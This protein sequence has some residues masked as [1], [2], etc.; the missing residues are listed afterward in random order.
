MRKTFFRS[1]RI[2]LYI[3]AIGFCCMANAYA[4]SEATERKKHETT[5]D[6]AQLGDVVVRGET[7]QK[8]LETTSATVL[9][10]EDITNRVFVTPLDIVTLSPGVSV[11]QYSQG[12]T[13]ANFIMRGFSGNS[14]G[15]NTAIFL[16]GI[17]LNEGDGYADTNVINPEELQRVELIKG[18]SSALYGNYASA[19][20]LAFYTKKRVD[21]NQLKLQYGAHNTYE[22]NFVGGFS[23]ENWDHV[24]SIQTY[25]TDGYQDNSKWDRQNAAVRSTYHATDTLDIR[26]SARAF[27]SDWDAPGYLG[28]ED[29]K[30]DRTQ[31]VSETNG[32][33]K[34]RQEARLDLDYQITPNAKILFNTWGYS[35]EFS[36]WYAN[37]PSNL[38]DD[39]IVGNLR[40]FERDV[41]GTGGSYNFAGSLAGRKLRFTVGTD[42]MFEDDDRNRWRLLAGT[43]RE[44]GPKFWDYNI[45]MHTFSLYTQGSYQILEPLRVVLGGRYDHFQGDMT[46][47]LDGGETFSMEEQNIFS[48]KGGVVL[49]F[50][51]N[52]LELYGNYSEGFALMPGFSEQAA[53]RQ[54]DWDPQE[55]TQYESGV[56]IF[57]SMDLALG[58]NVYR[59][60]TDKDY[61]L[62]RITDEYENVG[63]TT[64]DGVEI[65]LDYSAYDYGH[66]YLDYGYVD[67]T[68]DRFVSDGKDLSGKTLRSVPKN[69]F[70]AEIR[71]TPPRGF[72]GRLRYHY[73]DGY[74]L[75]DANEHK[76]ESWERVDAQ[77]SYRFGQNANYLAALD[78]VNLLDKEYADYTA[79]TT[80][81][82]YSPA[83]PLSL[84]ATLTVNF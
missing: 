49:T 77:V 8:D 31:A 84:Y 56:R 52:R 44:K 1:I 69:I 29:Y 70:N 63:S 46:D 76:S 43:G 75:D 28:E 59:L 12:G 61:I 58:F 48:P 66:L 6:A 80:E 74:Y 79:G 37:D 81:R 60:E 19:G 34:S 65:T 15:S 21:Q 14:H 51:E 2:L 7:T 64:R 33:R 26:L 57:P 24:Y 45:E 3:T 72:G 39:E 40:T 82:R 5:N 11:I 23:N 35:Q 13:A 47:Y 20:T 55:R 17:P 27:D 10:H 18:P 53:F 4:N 32:G 22:A 71:Y 36:R 42:Y 9:H 68:Y 16:D 41:I 25:H 78:I 54:E 83:L 30:R 73:E 38:D 50:L 62:N 67:A